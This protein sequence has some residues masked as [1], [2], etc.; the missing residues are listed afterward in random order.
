MSKRFETIFKKRGKRSCIVN[1]SSL[2]AVRAHPSLV[3]YSATKGFVNY[4]GLSQSVE[5][6]NTSSNAIDY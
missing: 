4:L 5:L 2:A 3:A 6:S 1:V